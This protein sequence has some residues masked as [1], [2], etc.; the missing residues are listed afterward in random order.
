MIARKVWLERTVN[1]WDCCRTKIEL[2]KIWRMRKIRRYRDWGRRTPISTSNWLIWIIWYPSWKPRSQ[3]RMA[4]LA[5]AITTTMAN[6]NRSS[7]SSSPKS[8]KYSSSLR[9]WRISVSFWKAQKA[10]AKAREGTWL[11]DAATS[12]GR[13]ESTRTSTRES[14][15][16]WNP[17]STTP[18]I[19]SHT[20]NDYYTLS[21]F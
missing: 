8:R 4:C 20:K 11:T 12:K 2:Y 21:L 7:S 13:R 5:G 14:A 10:K 18:S 6:Y 15:K 9:P 1:C 19:R 17:E 3:R 16:F